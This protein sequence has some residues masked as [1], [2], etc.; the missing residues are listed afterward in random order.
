MDLPEAIADTTRSSLGVTRS[1]MA[2]FLAVADCGSFSQAAE[3]LALSQSTL[4]QRIKQLELA[5]GTTLFDRGHQRVVLSAKGAL[6]L[7]LAGR[8]LRSC[9]DAQNG[10]A[11]WKKIGLPQVSILGSAA[12]MPMI[13]F[14]LLQR[15]KQEFGGAAMRVSEALSSDIRRQV[16]DGQSAL[17]V[18]ADTDLHPQLRY[19]PVLEVQ[20]GLLASP[21]CT[22]PPVIDSL[23]VLDGVQMVRSGDG[24]AVTQ[25]LRKHC[26]QFRAY[27]DAPV[28]V[29]DVQAATEL[30]VRDALV[31]VAT[32]VGASHIRAR[33]LVFIPLPKLLPIINVYIVSRRDAVFDA[34]QERLRDLLRQSVH[35]AAWHAAV[36]RVGESL[37]ARLLADG[38]VE[39]V[40]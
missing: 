33:G 32:G 23:G 11:Q 24:A 25:V 2:A 26:P 12:V 20:L 7:P 3:R 18:C 10:M 19:T 34:R 29:D 15:L 17:G 22:L 1:Q 16:L 38:S 9:V 8:V 14:G 5:L 37:E 21:E 31:T 28:V 36:R 39:S 27:F 40:A 30:I 35:D 4:S 13:A 6:L